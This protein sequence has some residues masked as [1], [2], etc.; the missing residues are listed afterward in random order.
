MKN[1][2]MTNEAYLGIEIGST[3]IKAV[4]IDKETLAPLS[5][6]GYLWKS[7]F[8]NGIWTYDIEEA[9]KGINEA[10]SQLD[11]K[12]EF[13]AVGISGM[14]H[15]YLAFDENWN[16]LT[17]FRTWQNTITARSAAELSEL[18]SFNMPQR[19]S[20]AHLYEAVLSSEEHVSRVAHITTIAGYI[21]YMLTGVNAVGIGEASGI[22]PIDSEKITYD[23]AMLEKFNQKLVEHGFT[24]RAEDVFPKVLTAGD[25]AGCLTATGEKALGGKIKA[26][27][28]FAPPEGDAG[29]GMVATNSI[30]Y[31][32]GNISAGT[33]IFAMV[34]L[35]KHLSKIYEEI[36]MVT[37]PDGKPV[38]MVHCNNCTGDINAWVSLFKGV[39]SLFGKD[40]SSDELYTKLYKSSVNGDANCGGIIA[41]NYLAGE[42]LT[43]LD[44]GIPMLLRTPDSDF[45]LANFMRA[46]IYGSLAT[47]R[48]GMD[49]FNRENVKIS[50]LTAHGGLLKTPGVAQKYMAAAFN[51][52]VVCLETSGEGGPYGMALL[53]AYM[54]EKNLG[55]TLDEFLSSRVFSNTVTTVE[56]AT[57]SEVADFNEYIE[58][59]KKMLAVERAAVENL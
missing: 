14:M 35:E 57:E 17:P 29:T 51:T 54:N 56:S 36:D 48:L 49:I 9:W 47:L 18:F 1:T 12:I 20:A 25:S 42:V 38:A 52:D 7:S 19:W 28:P 50:R 2:K 31:N 27:T 24:R 59:Y 21:H 23:E 30:S 8:S 44:K 37:T 11:E 4:A 13:S 43:G 45:S 39:L 6:G 33:S 58:K 16:L 15:G 41:C 32:T 10:L 46:Q 34:V 55:L 53:A 22:F 3:R 40:V 5:S 26:S